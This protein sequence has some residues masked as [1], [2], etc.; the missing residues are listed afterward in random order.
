MNAMTSC[1]AKASLARKEMGEPK[2]ML[3]AL[4]GGADSVALLC[5]LKMLSEQD[6]FEIAAIHVH[7]GLRVTADR[8][9]QFCRSLCERWHIPFFSVHVQLKNAS[10]QEAREARYVAFSTVYQQWNADAL[11]TAHHEADQAETVIMHLLRGS[12]SRGL[13]GMTLHSVQEIAGVTVK[14]LRPFLSVKKETLV[15]ISQD[16]AGGFCEDETNASDVYL[17]NFLRLKIMPMLKERWPQ[18]EAAIGRTAKILQA[19]NE[20]MER[21]ANKFLKDH[22]YGFQWLQIVEAQPFFA[23]HIAMR[24]RI[25]Q[26]FIPFDEE[27]RTIDDAT[28][29]EPGMT[30]NLQK[31]WHIA[32]TER[33]IYLLPPPD[34]ENIPPKTLLVKEFDGFFGDGIQSQAIPQSLAEQC[35]LRYRQKGDYIQPFGMQGTKSLQDY[36]VDR[37]VDAPLRDC[38]PIMCIGKEV[39]WAIGVGPSERVRCYETSDKQVLLVYPEKIPKEK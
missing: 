2:R 36:F 39:V 19:E 5:V 37:K 25:M 21:M 9:E 16:I 24:R 38:L 3:I 13:G 18:T 15:Q 34:R 11:V 7:H 28:N 31:N 20:W 22:S 14:I 33:R 23:Q 4:S 6:K 17:R 32:A 26:A 10:E 12:G 29:I 35:C 30:V 27:F 8:D 1:L